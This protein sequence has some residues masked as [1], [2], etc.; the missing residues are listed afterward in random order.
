MWRDCLAIREKKI[1]DDWQ[2]FSTRSRLG[3]ALSEE[4]K[5]AEAEPLLLSGYEG[6]KQRE[7]KISPQDKPRIKEA[8]ERLA[9]LYEN[10]SRPTEAAEWKRKLAEFG[11]S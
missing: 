5:Y 1:P 10:T 4:R 9:Q 2:C 11:K 3:G 7:S 8:L 6:M